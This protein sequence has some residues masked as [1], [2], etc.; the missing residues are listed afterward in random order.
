MKKEEKCIDD[1]TKKEKGSN[2][3]EKNEWEMNVSEGKERSEEGRKEWERN[4]KGMRKEKR[5]RKEGWQSSSYSPLQ[6]VCH[7]SNTFHSHS[8]GKSTVCWQSSGIL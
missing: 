4:E 1:G 5:N 3:K 6:R 7:Y 2:E 8:L